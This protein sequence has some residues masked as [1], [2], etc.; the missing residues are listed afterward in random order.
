M[1]STAS[2]SFDGVNDVAAV[3]EFV[4]LPFSSGDWT[5]EAWFK[6]LNATSLNHDTYTVASK[7][8]RGATNCDMY[9]LLRFRNIEIG[10]KN[11][12]THYLQSYRLDTAP[13]AYTINQ[14]IHFAGTYDSTNRVLR[15]YVDGTLR[16]TSAT[17]AAGPPDTTADFSIGASD[18]GAP[19][20]QFALGKIDEVRVW[21]IRRSDAQIADY[22]NKKA[23]GSESGLILNWHID[24]GS[25]TNL[26]D[27]SSSAQDGTIIG[28]TWD[29]GD[30]PTLTDV[31]GGTAFTANF[32]GASSSAGVLGKRATKIFV[33]VSVNPGA[34]GKATTKRVSGA[35]ISSGSMTR[36]M[37]RVLVASGVSSSS[38]LV[39][40]RLSKLFLAQ[41]SNSAI[42]VKS[43]SK[44]VS[45]TSGSTG[46][47]ARSVS[48]LLQGTAA[49]AGTLAKR[50]TKSWSGVSTNAG[51]LLAGAL[52]FLNV[53]GSST[54][55]GSLQTAV[56]HIF[57]LLVQ[58]A[59]NNA[60]RLS[61]S[62]TKSFTG[63]S[64]S[65]GAL[66][67]AITIFMQGSSGS[68]GT[69]TKDITK[70]LR[71]AS[72]SLG[73]LVTFL[74]QADPRTA[75]DLFQKGGKVS[76]SA[77]GAVSKMIRGIVGIAR[78]GR[79]DD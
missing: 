48:K 32:S 49:N 57:T 56:T 53:S 33:G 18:A 6:D 58:G 76:I 2:L 16:A 28:A 11:G 71:G 70:W 14:W 19:W 60:G 40:K 26:D 43:T 8:N 42:L 68:A 72:S 17:L 37:L 62:V 64:S 24:E 3:A 59:S 29:T 5:V 52:K 63:Q 73:S 44:R 50:I 47:L 61:R 79:V 1:P 34:L 20:T 39:S 23:S 54:S 36:S 7:N 77:A 12:G 27:V 15:I 35:S 21:N 25:G 66:S 51:A 55:S 13:E 22:Y 30:F 74:P 10:Y 31:G 67:R 38:G 9:L 69:L 4:A 41:S 46:L 45:G 75:L 78:G 65:A